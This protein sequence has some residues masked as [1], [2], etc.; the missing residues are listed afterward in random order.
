MDL[1]IQF[2]AI[3]V[4]G[5]VLYVAYWFYTKVEKI[6]KKYYKILWLVLCFLYIVLFLA[7]MLYEYSGVKTII[8][9]ILFTL[10][11]VF[12][13]FLT[14]CLVFCGKHPED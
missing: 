9:P 3:C 6:I 13:F 4:I 10:C 5:V 2:V 12:A 14:C 8:A 1:L 11:G 7:G